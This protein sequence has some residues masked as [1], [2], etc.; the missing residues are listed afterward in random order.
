MPLKNSTKLGEIS[1]RFGFSLV[2][3]LSQM[4]VPPKRTQM[5][6]FKRVVLALNLAFLGK[7]FPTKMSD[8]FLTA[9]KLAI[10]QFALCFPFATT[11][12]TKFC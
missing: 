12:L 6:F 7:S 4:S 3:V 11:L 2:L 8:K 1:R 9:Q 5:F 10:A